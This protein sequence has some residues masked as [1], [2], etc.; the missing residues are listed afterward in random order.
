MTLVNAPI[1]LLVRA[2]V[3]GAIWN[4]CELERFAL[5][6]QGDRTRILVVGNA[7]PLREGARPTP[8]CE[9]CVALDTVYRLR[10]L[11]A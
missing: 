1:H 8:S 5:S 10:E 9:A 7:W 4:A 11:G 6:L 2:G 3:T